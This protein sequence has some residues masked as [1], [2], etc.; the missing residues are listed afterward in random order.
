M[1]FKTLATLSHS[2]NR[3]VLKNSS[4]L[5]LH[6]CN[7]PLEGGHILAHFKIPARRQAGRSLGS[8][9]TRIVL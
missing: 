9:L 5:T 8:L 6:A 7:D 1:R 3:K 4:Q 2:V